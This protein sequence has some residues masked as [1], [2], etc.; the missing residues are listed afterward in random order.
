MLNQTPMLNGV[1]G[2]SV[3]MSLEKDASCMCVE[4]KAHGYWVQK[5]MSEFLDIVHKA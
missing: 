3:C 4:V 5:V 1:F 2:C